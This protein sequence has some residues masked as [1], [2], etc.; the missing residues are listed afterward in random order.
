MANLADLLNFHTIDL[1][2]FIQNYRVILP[3]FVPIFP[4]MSTHNMALL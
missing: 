2:M 4:P 3:M 1:L